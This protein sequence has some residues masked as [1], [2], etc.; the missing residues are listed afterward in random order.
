MQHRN[1]RYKCLLHTA[2]SSDLDS[3]DIIRQFNLKAFSEILYNME[4]N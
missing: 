4:R 3:Y 2:Y 1:V